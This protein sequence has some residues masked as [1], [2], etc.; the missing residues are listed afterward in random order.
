MAGKELPSSVTLE[1]AMEIPALGRPLHLGTL[2]DCR[3][4]TFIPGITLWDKETLERNVT[5]EEQCKT[6]FDILTSDS[7]DEK[8]KAM[9]ISAELKASVLGGLVKIGGSAKYLC[10]T[11]TSQRQARVTLKYSMTTQY[12]HLTMNHL[13][14]QNIA[15]HDVFDKG[16]ATHVVTAVLYGAQAFFVFDQKVSTNENVKDIEGTLKNKVKK[17]PQVSGKAGGK[18]KMEHSKKKSTK[19]FRCKFYGDFVLQT[20]LMTY[21]D[22]VEAYA[23]LPKLLRGRGV[24]LQVWLYPLEKL[25]SKAARLAR[26]ISISLVC[27]AQDTL[28]KLSECDKRCND[29]LEAP[30]LS[31]FP[32]IMEKVSL[33][34]ELNKQHRQLLQKEIA[35]AL[36]LIRTGRAE[37]DELT[38]ILIRESQSPFSTNRLSQF[39]D[40]KLQEMKVLKSYLTL[41]KEVPVIANQNE[42]DDVVIGSPHRFVLVF[43]LTSLQEEPYLA[44]W[45]QWLRNP[46]SFSP[47][48]EQKTYS[49]WVKDRETRRKARQLAESFSTFAKANHSTEKTHFIV[50]SVP[51]QENKG[52]SIYLYEKGLQVSTNFELPVKP[53]PPQ[54]GE[55]THDCVELTVTSASRQEERIT[56]YQVEYQVV[57][58]EDWTAIPVS[59]KPEVFKVRGLQP[60]TEYLFRFAEVCEPGLSESSDVSLVVRTL[61]LTWP[62]GKPEAVVVGP[63]SVTLHWDGPRVVGAGVKIKDYRIEYREESEAVGEEGEGEWHEQR[64]GNEGTYCDV[65]GLTPQTVYRFRVSAVCDGGRTS[66]SSDK[67]DPVRTLPTTEE[68]TVSEPDNSGGDSREPELRIVLVGKT[69]V[70][71]SAT[72]NTILSRKEFKSK[73]SGKSLTKVCRK[74]RGRW[75][76]RDI[77]VVDTPGIFDTDTAEKENLEEIAHFMTLSS[78]GPHALLL[79]LQVG[80]FTKEEKAA[81]ERLCNILGAEAVKFLIIVFTG[82]DKLGE[83]SIGDFLETI[84]DSY[85]KEL[86][87]KCEHRCCA[88]DN[89]ASGALTH[90]QVSELMAMVEKMVQDN[91]GTHY[92]NNIY[93][94]VEALLQEDTEA[95]QQRYKKQFEKEREEIRKKYEKLTEGLKKKMK[96][97]GKENEQYEKQKEELEKKKKIFENKKKAELEE[98]N[99]I[100]KKNYKRARGEAENNWNTLFQIAGFI[101]SCVL[102]VGIHVFLKKAF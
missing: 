38:S 12:S 27:N 94:S 15:Y 2:Y 5:T 79:V 8:T 82:K 55:V 85:F 63:Q 62:P 18:M 99:L 96:K 84:D 83:E 59:G 92:T 52:V 66:D 57:G 13:G 19:E 88:F 78:P 87:E 33:F 64:T 49:S 35:K 60:S 72:G 26:G 68:A 61:P 42:V 3:S 22:A 37:E 40:Q 77:S 34:Q 4:D 100:Y 101:L 69:G 30:E 97:L 75:N 93:E 1:T 50:A 10:D 45:K 53:P 91:G 74:A 65:D 54:I 28:E 43:A 21:K 41:L 90:A 6:D 31:V 71:K 76:G 14:Y 89:N 98:L 20:N 48:C 17:I 32:A 58:Q 16:T 44:D 70:G 7:I 95:R 11:K 86:L 46:A 36:P 25:S 51:E 9:N 29:M 73:C 39:L 56:G 80:R 24:P 102:S 23:S 81:V 67:S 47:D